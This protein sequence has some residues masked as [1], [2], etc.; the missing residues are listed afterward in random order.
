M[1]NLIIQTLISLESDIDTLYQHKQ[2]N[3]HMY[4]FIHL[5]ISDSLHKVSIQSITFENLDMLRTKLLTFF[6]KN[7]TD[8]LIDIYKEG[9]DKE[10]KYVLFT[11]TNNRYIEFCSWI[12]D[13]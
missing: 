1:N 8:S 10:S 12:K 6:D 5:D 2:P 9:Y 4:C 11:V 3:V 13:N 7:N